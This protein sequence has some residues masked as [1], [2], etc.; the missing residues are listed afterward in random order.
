MSFLR[1]DL[2]TTLDSTMRSTLLP[3]LLCTKSGVK[4]KISEYQK[5]KNLWKTLFCNDT[6]WKKK[7][8]FF[9][10]LWNF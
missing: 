1:P 2:K 10:K 8:F 9:S 4:N 5:R 7:H 6:R 3:Q